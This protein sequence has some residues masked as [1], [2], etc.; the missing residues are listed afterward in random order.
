M[1]EGF[2]CWVEALSESNY[3]IAQ[4]AVGVFL[5]ALAG[6][7]ILWLGKMEGYESWGMASGV[8]LCGGVL[9]LLQH[10]VKRPMRL[11]TLTNFGTVLIIFAGTALVRFVLG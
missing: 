4:I 2:A 11:L 6:A 10:L 1:R 3:R 8:V 9:N 5:G 7:A